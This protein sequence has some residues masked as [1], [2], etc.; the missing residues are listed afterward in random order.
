[1]ITHF[2]YKQKFFLKKTL[3]IR[4]KEWGDVTRVGE[5]E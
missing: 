3:I 2:G 1:M 5:N 4:D